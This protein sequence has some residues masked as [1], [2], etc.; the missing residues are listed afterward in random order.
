M[1]IELRKDP[2]ISFIVPVYKTPKDILKRCLMNLTDQDYPNKEIICV[3]DGS[4]KE[5]AKQINEFKKDGVKTLAMV[6]GGACAAR[7]AG[8]KI[9]TGEIISFFNSDYNAKP[10]MARMWVDELLA[11]P[12][13]G[14][15]Y[16][17]YEWAVKDRAWYAS[18]P[19][20]VFELMQAN[21]I[22][23]GFPLWRKHV[24]AWDVNCKS[25]QDWD[26]WIRVVKNGVK[27]H[28]MTRDISYSA[29]MPVEGGLSMDS[30]TNWMDRVNYVK[31]K[32]GIRPSSLVVTSLG[33]P[34]HGVQIAKMIGADYRDDTLFPNRPH[35]YKAMYMIGWFMSPNNEHNSHPS[36]MAMFE[37]Q[38]KVLHFVGA[39]IY[40]LRKFCWE[41][42]KTI[43]GGLN[44]KCNHILCETEKA[45]KEL[46]SLGVHSKVV[47]IPPYNDYESKP[48]PEKFSVA[49]FLTDKSSSEYAMGFDKYCKEKTMSIVRA[50]P[51]VQFNSYGD[52]GKDLRY[53][54]LKYH[55]NLDA[56]KWKEFVYS[57]AAYLRIVRHD[58]R[59]MASDEFI[60]AG[61]D[62]ITNVPM[63]Y[64]E[65]IYTGGD[66]SKNEW[67]PFQVGLNAHYWNRTKKEF[68][69]KIRD[70]RDDHE[71]GRFNKNRRDMAR[72]YYMDIL[73]RKKYIRTI[74]DL[75]GLSDEGMKIA[76]GIK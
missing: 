46:E 10:G 21:Y 76:G 58:T 3:L 47:P 11:N 9:S 62:V 35:P 7:N 64:M 25:L 16:G 34:Y 52:A 14:F 2:L 41:D 4:D 28:F 23:C 68:V 36:I 66:L 6:H 24:V 30:S 39:D 61:R 45:R 75:V 74:Y 27:G 37:N 73:D 15:A 57:N 29:R 50:M 43:T 18:K 26:F 54:N 65:H 67:D 40:W 56:E 17:P 44:L 59:P 42:L 53:P 72:K 1:T 70:L 13:C 63:A 8:F 33:A 60:L 55:G 69:R 51:D 49:I 48:M 12:D 31:I 38:T 5:L 32:N 20:N 22:D 71:A 19:F